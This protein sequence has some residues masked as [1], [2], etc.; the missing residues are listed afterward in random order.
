MFTQAYLGAFS[1]NWFTGFWFP[2]HGSSYVVIRQDMSRRP[3]FPLFGNG[4]SSVGLLCCL[5]ALL[6][7]WKLMGQCGYHFLS[8]RKEQLYLLQAAVAGLLNQLLCVHFFPNIVSHIQHCLLEELHVLVEDT[9][10]LLIDARLQDSTEEI[11]RDG[12]DCETCDHLRSAAPSL[13]L[14]VFY[15]YVPRV[16]ENWLARHA[17][18]AQLQ[19]T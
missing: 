18:V 8:I 10:D 16:P 11:H 9:L 5:L 19:A 2:Y 6:D 12:W 13:H 14:T 3:T 15:H 17:H 4:A 1:A 7:P